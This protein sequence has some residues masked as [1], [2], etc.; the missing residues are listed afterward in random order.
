MSGTYVDIARPTRAKT[1]DTSG[2]KDNTLTRGARLERQPHNN[3]FL[4]LSVLLFCQT[5]SKREVYLSK[6]P[7]AWMVNEA[8]YCVRSHVKPHGF[9]AAAK[10]KNMFGAGAHAVADGMVRCGCR[11]R[12]VVAC[13]VHNV[14]SI[15]LTPDHIIRIHRN[16]TP[17]NPKVLQ[18]L[19]RQ[20]RSP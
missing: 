20:R 7:V 17:F 15:M 19:G 10:N 3:S 11:T 1:V 18:F 9:F 12:C 6:E 5:A 8:V 16:P 2:I 14:L 13:F 4:S